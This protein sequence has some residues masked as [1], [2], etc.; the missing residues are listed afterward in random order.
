M[1]TVSIIK[2]VAMLSVALTSAT[3][4]EVELF[5]LNDVRLLDG[6]FKPAV[7]AN[8]KYILAHDPDRLLAPF[9]REAGLPPRKPIYPNWESSGLDGHT[10]GHYLSAL[11]EMI[12]S[13]SDT[14]DGELGRRLNYM[15]DE[16]EIC[17][18]TNG[19]GYVGSIPQSKTF[20]AQIAGGDVGRIRSR[21]VPWY[22]VHKTFAGLRD[23]YLLT[24]NQKA[25]ELMV[26]YAEW[27][28]KITSGLSDDQMQRM[29]NDEHGGINES[30]ADLYAITKDEKYL[31]L[32]KRFSH[33]AVLAPLERKEDRLN[34][35]HANTQI[36]KVIGLERIASLTGNKDAD[37]GARFFWEN[38]TTKRSVAFGGNSVS[39]H[40]NNPNDF[41]RMLEHREGPET[42]NTYNMLRLTEQLFPGK[43]DAAYADYYERA[44]FNHILSSINIQKPGYVYFTPIRPGHYRVYSQVEQGFWCCVG[45]GMENPGRYGQFIYAKDKDGV[46][47]NLFI[48]SEVNLPDRGIK[49][50]QETLF[51]EEAKT[52]LKVRLKSPATFA[53]RLRHPGWVSASEFKVKINGEAI[54]ADTKPASYASINREWKDGDQIEVELPMHTTTESLPDGSNWHAILYG[55]IVLA[56]PTG[57]ENQN[58]LFA[59]AG[60]GDHIAGGPLVAM[61]QM[62]VLL[63][64]RDELVKHVVP[65]PSAGAMHFRLKDVIVPESKD[66][67]PLVPFYKLHESR[68]Q[69]YFELT[70]K[71]GLAARQ[72]RLAEEE[73][74][75]LARDAATIDSVAVGEQQPET[76]HALSGEGMET[77]TFQNRRWRHGRSFQYTFSARGN[78]SID[79][80]ITYSGGDRDR[81]FDVLAN[82]TLLATEKLTGAAPGRFI[83]KRYALPEK[84][85]ADAPEGRITI[86]F[87]AKR[88]VAGGVYDVRLMKPDVNLLDSIS[89]GDE[90]SESAH[91]LVTENGKTGTHENRTWRDGSSILYLLNIRDAKT[92]NLVITY[93]GGDR[94]RSFDIFANDN[95]LATETLK[96]EKPGEFFDKQ[97]PIPEQVLSKSK[98]GKV[99]IKLVARQ[100]VAGGIFDLKLTRSTVGN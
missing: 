76:D 26:R 15:I 96:G 52:K 21:W 1:R 81:E 86:K 67:I 42:C 95:L 39:E 9:R 49:L 33:Q 78:K 43:P 13:G 40:F 83:E 91:G 38:V 51:P 3:R 18:Q 7:E 16:L 77:G 41:R 92:A 59:G 46:Y 12:A 53:I 23:A 74:A 45:T 90:Q 25:K 29:L 56:S 48:S 5:T 79:L 14:P 68:Y 64:S 80:A 60:R 6:P 34:G 70:T 87:V 63:A 72:Q 73:R 62:P 8:L 66:G 69:M 11:S 58:G 99:V 88:G 75:K 20:W 94:D 47:V 35:L 85:I 97:Y 100:W 55:P 84:V 22:T 30:F 54:A 32:A 2:W 61:D 50:I 10:A 36:P 4:A 27:A 65:D 17:Q 98:D 93:W 57:T 19:D 37:A 31:K 82:D 89:I 28:E 44:L 24:G 71:E